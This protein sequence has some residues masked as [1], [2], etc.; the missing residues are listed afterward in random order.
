MPPQGGILFSGFIAAIAL[1]WLWHTCTTNHY[2][3]C[4][5]QPLGQSPIKDRHFATKRIGMSVSCVVE[6]SPEPLQSAQSRNCDNFFSCR[7]AQHTPLL[8]LG[9]D[10]E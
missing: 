2:C 4:P 8:F 9:G 6:K 1:R 5:M 10:V 7:A 3:A